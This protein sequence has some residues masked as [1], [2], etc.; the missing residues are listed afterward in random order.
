MIDPLSVFMKVFEK[1]AVTGFEVKDG[2]VI[3]IKTSNGFIKTKKVVNCC[4]VWGKK[5]GQMAGVKVP[6]V[7][8]KH[9]YVVTEPVKGIYGV[10]NMRDH[11]P[12]VYIKRQV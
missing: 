12:S 2:Q 5:L 9:A 3:G 11:E 10:P 7:S 6:L 4:G 8:M 1:T